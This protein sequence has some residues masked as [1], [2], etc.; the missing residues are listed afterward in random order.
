M[1]CAT[2]G[3]DNPAG[4]PFCRGCGR[5]LAATGSGPPPAAQD[6]GRRGRAPESPVGSL[7]AS[8][9]RLGIQITRRELIGFGV[10]VVVG[11]VVAQVLPQV[12]PVLDPLLTLVFGS[13]PSAGRDGFNTLMMTLLTF[14]SSMAVSF[15]FFRRAAGG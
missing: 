12:Y 9:A 14:L 6:Q 2:C 8:L 1:K 3:R 5:S 7:L 11:M 13:G 15:V 10:A 4:R